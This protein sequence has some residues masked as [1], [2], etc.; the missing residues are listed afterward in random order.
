MTLAIMA[1][2]RYVSDHIVNVARCSITSVEIPAMR[3]NATV[4]FNVAVHPIRSKDQ[5]ATPATPTNGDTNTSATMII[6]IPLAGIVCGRMITHIGIRLAVRMAPDAIVT[7]RRMPNASGSSFLLVATRFIIRLE[8]PL[9]TKGVTMAD[10]AVTATN[11]P[12]W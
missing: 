3:V 2:A 1:A 6:A 11:A 4:A 9:P 5:N 10:V 7:A 12:Y 8:K